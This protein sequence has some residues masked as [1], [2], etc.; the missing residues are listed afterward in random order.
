[1]VRSPVVV[2]HCDTAVEEW[3]NCGVDYSAR[4]PGG[5]EKR[6]GAQECG[7][8]ESTNPAFATDAQERAWRVQKQLSISAEVTIP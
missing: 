8:D 5:L 1:M 3:L 7:C 4:P 6:K 2:G